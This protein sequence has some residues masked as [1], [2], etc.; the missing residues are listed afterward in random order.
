MCDR[1]GKCFPSNFYPFSGDISFFTMNNDFVAFGKGFIQKYFDENNDFIYL[2]K[3]SDKTPLVNGKIYEYVIESTC[4][5]LT[6][7]YLDILQLKGLLLFNDEVITINNKPVY[8]C[9]PVLDYLN[10]IYEDSKN[11]PCYCITY[12]WNDPWNN[13]KEVM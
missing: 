8:R 4:H 3:D 12:T 10:I 11:Y 6:D 5:P 7:G 9:K 2:I 13:L 1:I